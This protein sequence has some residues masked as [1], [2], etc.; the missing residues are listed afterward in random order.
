MATKTYGL[1]TETR[2]KARLGIDSTDA[3]RDA[4]FKSMVYAVTDFIE[5]ACGGRRFQRATYT[6]DKY[7]GNEIGDGTVLNWLTLKNGPVISVSSV[8]YATGPVSNPTW[9]D[10]PADSYQ[11]DL[12]LGQI[13][14]S[15]GMPRGMQ[16]IRVT[17]VA[18]YLIAFASEYDD[19]LHTL[20][21][22]IN[23]LAERLA[24]KVMKRRE[25]EGKSQESFNNSGITWGDF[26]ETHDREILANYRRVFAV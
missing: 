8:Q 7:D 1:T 10:F 11:V 2:L 18:G 21:F 6:N 5:N 22:D 15:G 26:L 17:Y 23:D 12:N 14:F 13:Y 16:N 19:T 20:P 3:A 4:V 24:T 25:S 9:V